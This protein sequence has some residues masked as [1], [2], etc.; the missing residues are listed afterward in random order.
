[1]ISIKHKKLQDALAI[2]GIAGV[3][4]FQILAKFIVTKAVAISIGPAGITFLS[5]FQNANDIAKLF[6][7]FGV[8][9][10]GVPYYARKTAK[11][12]ICDFG[13][14]YLYFLIIYLIC[15]AAIALLLSWGNDKFDAQPLGPE[16][17]TLVVSAIF[18]SMA[19]LNMMF[20]RAR[21]NIAYLNYAQIISAAL[22]AMVAVATVGDMST[23]KLGW[24]V[25][26]NGLFLFSTT[27][28]FVMLY[29]YKAASGYLRS[30]ILRGFTSKKRILLLQRKIWIG[31]IRPGGAIF[32][33]LVSGLVTELILRTWVNNSA[34]AYISGAYNAG[35]IVVSGYFGIFLSAMLVEYF[36]K[37]AKAESQNIGA[38][39]NDNLDL[40][41][42]LAAPLLM[43]LIMFSDAVILILFSEEF[44]LAAEFARVAFL[45]ALVLVV[46]N[47]I[48][49][50]LVCKKEFRFLIPFA[51]FY[52]VSQLILSFFFF[53]NY[54]LLGLGIASVLVSCIHFGGVYFYARQKYSLKINKSVFFRFY[55][56]FT[57][58][59]LGV[60]ISYSFG[61]IVSLAVQ[62]LIFGILIFDLINFF[63]NKAGHRL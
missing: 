7:T 3:K 37:L 41:I 19:E 46:S 14:Q 49:L 38:L 42:S 25:L 45:G 62:S 28:C 26:M 30:S 20:L 6:F 4:I 48:D 53:N 9:E 55:K 21:M 1:M 13:R 33:I 61:A 24:I 59:M 35:L 39:L 44:L 27:L 2:G 56:S 12:A 34:S 31:M 43:L 29:S 52:R 8:S 40:G 51:I 54:G 23:E 57:F 63:R 10:S 47:P 11:K 36:P 18:W 22:I 32:T 15:G 58:I 17:T 50:Y 16:I 5:I 60:A